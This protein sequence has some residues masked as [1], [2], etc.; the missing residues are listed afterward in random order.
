MPKITEFV[1]EKA[2]N[3]GFSGEKLFG[4]ELAV[5]EIVVNVFSYA[6]PKGREGNV[7]IGC[8]FCDNVFR[9]QVTDDGFPFNPLLRAAPNIDKDISERTIGGLGIFLA[10]EVADDISYERVNDQ[11]VLVLSFILGSNNKVNP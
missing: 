9:V 5:E 7:Q 4:I 11:N 10:R 2:E 8:L 6:Y 3:A 1:I